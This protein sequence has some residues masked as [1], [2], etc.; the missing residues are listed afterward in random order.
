LRI[1][2]LRTLEKLTICNY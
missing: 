1:K 2:S